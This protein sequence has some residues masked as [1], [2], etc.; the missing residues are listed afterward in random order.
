MTLPRRPATSNRQDRQSSPHASTT[1]G[2][3]SLDP[4][5]SKS[6]ATMHGPAADREADGSF[7]EYACAPE[8][9]LAHKPASLTFEQ[10]AVVPISGFAAL[11]GFATKDGC[12]RAR[13]P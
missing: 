2:E 12:S 6:A 7:A 3:W 10:A 5:A 8:D 9:N 1:T 4:F 13:R 11:Q